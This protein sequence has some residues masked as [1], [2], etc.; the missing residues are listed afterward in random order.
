LFSQNPPVREFLQPVSTATGKPDE[1]WI[2]RINPMV[3]QDEPKTIQQI[4]VRRNTL[5]GNLSLNQELYFVQKVNSWAKSG[6]LPADKFKEI[7][8]REI[9]LHVQLDLVSKFDRSPPYIHHLI[10]L[11]EREAR[12]FVEMLD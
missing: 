8:I 6:W 2:I 5:S 3:S 10:D 11:G 9:C 12:R 4:E 1:I 7:R